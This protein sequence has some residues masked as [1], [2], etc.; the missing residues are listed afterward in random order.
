M[1]PCPH[2]GDKSLMP[3]CDCPMSQDERDRNDTRD[4]FLDILSEIHFRDW[5]FCLLQ[6]DAAP[7][8]YFLVIEFDEPCNITGKPAT[9][10]SRKWLL[11]PQMTR[12]EIVQ[13]AWLAVQTAM[14]HEMREQF[15]YRGDAIFGPHF[16]IEGLRS[17]CHAQHDE[18][19]A[20]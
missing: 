3:F 7:G 9:Q 14:Q 16:D 13:T 6:E 12:G 5:R 4:S 2:C 19:R 8:I 17:L 11:T 20:A 1:D 10:T 18:R 15:L